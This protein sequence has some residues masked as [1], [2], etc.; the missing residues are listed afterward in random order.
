MSASTEGGPPPLF[1]RPGQTEILMAIQRY[2][3]LRVGCLNCVIGDRH[4]SVSAI[5][6]ASLRARGIT[7][8]SRRSISFDPDYPYLAELKDV[9][10]QFIER[11]D[12]DI[13]SRSNLLAGIPRPRPRSPIEIFGIGS[14]TEGLL[15][16]AAAGMVSGDVLQKDLDLDA[17]R[18]WEILRHFQGLGVIRSRKDGRRLIAEL[19]PEFFAAKELRHL[20]L[21]MV[22]GARGEYLGIAKLRRV[23][24]PTFQRPWLLSYIRD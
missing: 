9:L 20:L 7:T 4:V 3:T 2:G 24:T 18:A 16:L 11:F 15:Y 8:I 19:D 17:R 22:R 5:R 1:M 23:K 21:A 13:V 12:I 14:R 10:A 6:A